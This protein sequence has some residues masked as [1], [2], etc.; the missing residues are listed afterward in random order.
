MVRLADEPWSVGA[1]E[2][3]YWSQK[4][5]DRERIGRSGWVDFLHGQNT[6]Y[7]EQALEAIWT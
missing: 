2:V 6:A 4:A 5:Q 1:L 3:W 7:P